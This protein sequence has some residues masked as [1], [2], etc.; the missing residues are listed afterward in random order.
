MLILVSMNLVLH[1]MTV[2]RVCHC[3]CSKAKYKCEKSTK[4]KYLATGT[5]H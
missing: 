4:F 2:L 3:F 1:C 5:Q